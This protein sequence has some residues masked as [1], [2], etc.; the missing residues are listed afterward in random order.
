MIKRVILLKNVIYVNALQISGE[1]VDHS[2]ISAGLIGSHNWGISIYVLSLHPGNFQ[3]YMLH[4]ANYK[5]Q[6]FKDLK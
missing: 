3:V 1:M 5:E 4:I 2:I 6:E